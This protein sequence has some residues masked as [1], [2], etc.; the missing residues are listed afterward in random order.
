MNT[1]EQLPA[2]AVQHLGAG[3]LAVLEAA[4]AEAV[5]EERKALADE[6][7]ALLAER[8]ERLAELRDAEQAAGLALEGAAAE[9]EAAEQSHHDAQVGLD[10]YDRQARG[11]REQHARAI[12]VLRGEAAKKTATLP[13]WFSRLVTGRT[14]AAEIAA[15]LEV[16]IGQHAAAIAVV[17]ARVRAERP[18]LAKAVAD[19]ER[20]LSGLR[21]AHAIAEG[22]WRAAYG[23]LDAARHDYDVRIGRIE[24]QLH[25]ARPAGLQRQFIEAI[26]AEDRRL[27][28]A[29]IRVDDTLATPE[30]GNFSGQRLYRRATNHAATEARL[31]GLRA[32]RRELETTWHLDGLSDVEWQARFQQR[33]GALADGDEMR[34]TGD[35]W[36]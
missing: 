26:V 19:T 30:R 14:L 24:K 21:K 22:E 7:Q 18:G 27:C 17:D 35:L 29:S 28:R 5:T 12:E 6:R 8:D 9:L 2:W 20:P 13:G 15:E 32:L 1:T 4:D 31:A 34:N 11:E 36:K 16:T 3:G 23:T 33:M 25:D 10:E